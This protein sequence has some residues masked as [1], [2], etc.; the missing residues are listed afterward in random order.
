MSWLETLNTAD[1]ARAEQMLRACCGASRWATRVAALRPFADA[2][3]LHAAA[4]QCWAEATESDLLEAFAAHPMI[5]DVEVLKDKFNRQAHAEQGQVAAA[6]DAVISALA[7]RNNEYHEKFGFI[8]IV[9]ASG[10]SAE[11]MLALL[12]ARID[13]DRPAELAN[14]AAEQAKITRLRLDAALAHAAA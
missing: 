10:K 8:F 5:G 14:A 6:S 9:C 11:E 1:A 7:R 3:A 12:E 13:N 4:E 2:A